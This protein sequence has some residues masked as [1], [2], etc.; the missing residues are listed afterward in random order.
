LLL[1]INQKIKKS[2]INKLINK[3]IIYFFIYFLIKKNVFR[4]YEK[5]DED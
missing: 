2:K 4:K 3:K 1:F 5:E